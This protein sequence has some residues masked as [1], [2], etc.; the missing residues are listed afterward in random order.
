Q[1]LALTAVI[2]DVT[3][4]RQV[5]D[6]LR[7]REEQLRQAQKMEAIVRLAGGVAHDFNNLLMAIHGYAEMLVQG[8]EE[9]DERKVDAQEILDAAERAAG[10]TRQLLAFSRRQVITQQAIALDQLVEATQ[11]MLL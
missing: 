10:L 9:G 11:K 8:F 4:R 3:E 1:G 2:R 6:A 5:Q 7:Q